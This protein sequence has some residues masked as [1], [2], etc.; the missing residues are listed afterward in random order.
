MKKHWKF[1]FH[2][3]ISGILVAVLI[4]A[5]AV[6]PLLA[7]GCSTGK[8]TIEIGTGAQGGRYYEYAGEFANLA[9]N[10]L[11]IKAQTTAGSA[12]NIRLLQKGFLDAAIVQSDVLYCASEGIG[13]FDGEAIKG[14]M[15]FGAIAGLYDE[16][17]QIVVR[18]DSGITSIDELLGK[19]VSVGEKE[20]GVIQNAEQIMSL[21][22]LSFDDTEV[23][24]LSYDD[25][26]KKI[27]NGEID[28]FFCMAGTPVNVLENLTEDT[29]IRLLSFS[30]QDLGRIKK[31]YPFYKTVTIPAGTYRGVDEDI[32]TVGVQAVLVASGA[33][34]REDAGL[35]TECLYTNMEKLSQNSYSSV[36][37]P[38][39]PGAY[40]YYSANGIQVDQMDKT[41]TSISFGSQDE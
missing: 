10:D 31:L 37:V 35:L 26:A 25:A 4:V 41:G 38:F 13:M 7:S 20:S 40:D 36:P 28:A 22:G 34:S 33:L 23:F 27:K 32:H 1:K 8:P 9:K 12:A 3:K 16:S 24:Y 19:R 14:N 11:R 5:G 15:K 39:H 30:E 17:L 2:K 29:D 6:F 21:Y 18:S